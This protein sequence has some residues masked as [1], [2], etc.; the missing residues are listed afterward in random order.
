[1]QW[2]MTIEGVDEFGTAHGVEIEITKDVN[3][4]CQVNCIVSKQIQLSKMA[5]LPV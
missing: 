3:W 2:K 1:M 5:M 4:R